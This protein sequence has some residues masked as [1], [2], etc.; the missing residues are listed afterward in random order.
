[1]LFDS[2]A[3]AGLDQL[4]CVVL[5]GAGVD[6][7]AGVQSVKRAGGFIIAQDQVSAEHF[8]MPEASIKTGDV[9][10]VLP[11]VN[12]ANAILERLNQL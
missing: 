7:A 3:R 11:A 2:L 1:L 6:G 8:G 4:I 9:D 12:I 5:S 10:R